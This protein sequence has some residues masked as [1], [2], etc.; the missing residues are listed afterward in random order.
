MSPA[1]AL[2]IILVQG[3][4]KA[5][6]GGVPLRVGFLSQ[7][8]LCPFSVTRFLCSACEGPEQQG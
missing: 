7:L 6:C 1:P 8:F 4:E 3:L 5:L 2:A